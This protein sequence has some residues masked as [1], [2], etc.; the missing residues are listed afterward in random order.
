[1][2]HSIRTEKCPIYFNDMVATIASSSSR[3]GLRSSP[4]TDLYVTPRLRT[5]LGKRVFYYAGPTA[6]NTRPANIRSETSQTKFK[7]CLKH[8][9][10]TSLLLINFYIVFM[11][12]ACVLIVTGELEM[13]YCNVYLNTQNE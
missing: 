9:F 7:N 10:L 4:T 6:W 8:T 5:K 1:M 12:C 13:F 2:M 3:S 11:L